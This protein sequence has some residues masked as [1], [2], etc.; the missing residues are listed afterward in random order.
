MAGVQPP[1]IRELKGE[2]MKRASPI[3]W[4]TQVRAWVGTLG[5]VVEFIAKAL[6]LWRD[7]HITR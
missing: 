3:R 6:K 7:F 4:A 5:V 2:T 1:A